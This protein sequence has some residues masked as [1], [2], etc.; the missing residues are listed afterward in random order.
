MWPLVSSGALYVLR[1]GF[2]P[3]FRWLLA[4]KFDILLTVK[5]I[6]HGPGCADTR[7]KIPNTRSIYIYTANTSGFGDQIADARGTAIKTPSAASHSA[8]HV[9]DTNFSSFGLLIDV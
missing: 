1:R 5:E 4:V 7:F 2:T 6:K 3:V 8:A 9:E